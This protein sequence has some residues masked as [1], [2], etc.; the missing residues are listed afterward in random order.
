MPLSVAMPVAHTPVPEATPFPD[1]HEAHPAPAE[2]WGTSGG[3]EHFTTAHAAEGPVYRT[4]TPQQKGRTRL[5]V[6][7][8]LCLHLSAMALLA[9]WIFGLFERSPDPEPAPVPAKKENKKR[10]GKT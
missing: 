6:V 7:L 8:G 3:G 2:E 9:A 5:L 4:R 1:P 10:A